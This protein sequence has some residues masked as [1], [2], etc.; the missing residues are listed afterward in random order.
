[1]PPNL[2]F[3]VPIRRVR[4]PRDFLIL[5]MKAIFVDKRTK[6]FKTPPISAETNSS[7]QIGQLCWWA[8]GHSS[9]PPG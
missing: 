5:Y 3:F 6:S 1:M 8:G 9:S 2:L 4:M 7:D